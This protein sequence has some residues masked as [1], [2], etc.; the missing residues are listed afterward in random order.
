MNLLSS[1]D[2]IS[3][4]N[5]LKKPDSWL[6]AIAVTLAIVHLTMIW[7]V[8][9]LSY[10]GL[11]FLFWCAVASL[12]G[13]KR[14][15]LSLKSGM[16]ASLFAI[17]LLIPLL[18][19]SIFLMTLSTSSL[20]IFPVIAGFSLALLAS[21]FRGLPQYRR[22]LLILLVLG[23]TQPLVNLLNNFD[24]SFLTAKFATLVLWYSGFDIVRQGTNIYFAGSTNGVEVYPGCSGLD[25]IMHLLSLTL[26]FFLL[27]P[28]NLKTKILLPLA[29]VVIG[30]VANGIRVSLLAVIVALHESKGFEYWHAGEG[31]LL[32]S[33]VSAGL[34]CGVAFL[35]VQSFFKSDKTTKEAENSDI[36][37]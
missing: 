28:S 14:D 16:F 21:G 8:G 35:L 37:P 6:A 29:A 24:P 1:K 2:L 19:K 9:S 18:I 3:S 13:D 32:F 36:W 4:L 5:I 12:I 31:S 15:T 11:S 33:M 17:A 25:A 20:Y 30:F 23:L 22:E 10:G 27:F 7:R 26:L 34:L